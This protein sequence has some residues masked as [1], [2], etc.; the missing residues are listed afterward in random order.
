[1][2]FG[3]LVQVDAGAS[4]NPEEEFSAAQLNLMKWQLA[5]CG[6]VGARAYVLVAANGDLMA[7]GAMWNPKGDVSLHPTITHTLSTGVYEVTWATQ[8]RDENN[9]LQDIGFIATEVH[10]QGGVFHGFK[11]TISGTTVTVT[12]VE[13][14]SGTPEDGRFLLKVY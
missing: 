6:I 13:G 11:S 12:I 10:P 2:A 5:G 4:T 3:P 14:V 1:M 8:Y 7:A 9:M